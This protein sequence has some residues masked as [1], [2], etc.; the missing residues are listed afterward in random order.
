MV[1]LVISSPAEQELA[2]TVSWYLERSIAAAASFE[3]EFNRAIQSIAADPMRNP[4]CDSRHHFYLLRRFPFRI[5]Y[6]L[7]G[8]TVWVIC[9][10]HTSRK[11]EY[12]DGRECDSRR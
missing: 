4:K 8:E 10:A 5:I 6:R 12:W 2:D 11:P 3:D 9:V 1:E 7:V